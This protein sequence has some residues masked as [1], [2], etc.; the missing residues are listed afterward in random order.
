ML[1]SSVLQHLVLH[2]AV[3]VCGG[4]RSLGRVL[5]VSDLELRRWIDGHD[6]APLPVFN[7]ALRLVNASYRPSPPPAGR[8]GIP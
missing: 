6:A 2:K 7:R 4:S 3:A 5:N 8:A 1:A